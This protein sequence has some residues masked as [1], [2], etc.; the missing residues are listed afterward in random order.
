MT[1]LAQASSAHLE[2]VTRDANGQ[3]LQHVVASLH[4]KESIAT[5]APT[6]VVS[7]M[8]QRNL[9]FAP[10]V[11]AVQTGTAVKFP[12]DDDVRHHVYSFSHPNAFELKLYHGESGA[13]QIFQHEGV[14]VLGCNIHDGMLGY[15]RVVDT[16]YF[17][18]SNVNG[19]L[20]IPDVPPGNY[21]LQIWHPDI[22]MTVVRKSLT[23]KSGI[24]RMEMTV[25]VDR[26]DIP[27]VK[28]AHPLQSL[29]RD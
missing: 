24:S 23:V 13:N 5:V 14:V 15:L 2:L 19:Y 7:I 3:L 21:E 4:P 1:P 29:F 12:N 6:D 28:A 9:Q 26:V 20:A 11:L 8:D 10:T 17:S 22:G 27:P 25:A 18:T 16:P